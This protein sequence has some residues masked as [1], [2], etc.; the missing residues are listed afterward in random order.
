[1]DWFDRTQRTLD[2][3]SSSVNSPGVVVLVW[4][5]ASGSL[6]RQSDFAAPCLRG[7]FLELAQAG[8]PDEMADGLEL[9]LDDASR[10]DPCAASA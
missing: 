10:G 3:W 4:D 2:D 7:R 1:L 5:N 9:I 6:V 8:T